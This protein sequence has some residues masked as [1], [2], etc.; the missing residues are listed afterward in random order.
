MTDEIE[1]EVMP[2]CNTTGYTPTPKEYNILE[3]LLNP[4]HRMKS[5]TDICRIALCSRT[6]YYEAFAKPEFRALYEAKAKDLVKQSIAP[7]LNT[8][9]REALKGNFNHGKL[10]LEMAGLYVEKQRLDIAGDVTLTPMS[11]EERRARISEL[12]SKRQVIEALPDIE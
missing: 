1:L 5:I 3:V 2:E 4:E 9:V 12:M 11:R 7:I 8:F 6:V 10:L